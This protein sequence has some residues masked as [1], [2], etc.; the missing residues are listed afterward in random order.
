MEVAYDAAYLIWRYSAWDETPQL[1]SQIKRLNK[2][3]KVMKENQSLVQ[4]N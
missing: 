4:E 3:L 2:I 1:S